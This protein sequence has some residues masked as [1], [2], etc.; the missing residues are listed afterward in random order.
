METELSTLTCGT[1]HIPAIAEGLWPPLC[2]D[3]ALPMTGTS[4]NHEVITLLYFIL[5]LKFGV[6]WGQMG[7][8]PVLKHLRHFSCHFIRHKRITCVATSYL[9]CRAVF[10]SPLCLD[11]ITQHK[12]CDFTDY[13]W[14]QWETPMTA[15]LNTQEN[16]RGEE[17]PAHS[18]RPDGTHYLVC[19]GFSLQYW[20]AGVAGD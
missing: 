5:L 15:V 4:Y 11:S 19:C 13:Q 1:W 9:N 2:A 12:V 6:L 3:L 7:L 20:R 16:S 17:E 18:L 10:F 14:L 8:C